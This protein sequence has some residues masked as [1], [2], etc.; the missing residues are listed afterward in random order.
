MNRVHS[1]QSAEQLAEGIAQWICAHI[2]QVLDNQRFYTWALSGG[3]T[4]MKLYQ[5]LGRQYH[6]AVDWKRV[7]FF[8]G[9]ERLVPSNDERNNAAKACE[10]F[11]DLLDIDPLQIHRVDTQKDAAVAAADYEKE[12]LNF[13][14]GF[15]H[16]F[17]LA[18]LGLGDDGH[19]L[20]VF[21]G[22]SEVSHQGDE[23]VRYTRHP[24]DGTTRITLMP[25]IINRS[26]RVAFMVQGEGKAAILKEVLQEKDPSYPAGLIQ[27]VN[28]ELHWFIDEAAGK[29]LGE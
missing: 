10:V 6:E 14:N 5:L 20:S 3:S 4:P 24:S 16:T 8:W 27:P 18:L 25:S 1:Y 13:F 29:L 15:S 19:T 28:N 22:S 17:D 23:W 11:L 12:L 21:P 26:R 9:D 7:H 2:S